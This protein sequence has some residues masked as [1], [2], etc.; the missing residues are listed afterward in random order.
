MYRFLAAASVAVSFGLA[1]TASLP[2]NA[3]GSHV[4][5]KI[6]PIAQLVI[7]N[8]GI[9]VLRRPHALQHAGRHFGHHRRVGLGSDF[10]PFWPNGTVEGGTVI[11]NISVGQGGGS[12]VQAVAGIREAPTA[13]PAIYVLDSEGRQRAERR[14]GARVLERGASG[15]AELDEGSAQSPYSPRIVSVPVR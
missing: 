3:G 13:R 6:R 8:P 14:S 1:T 9:G 4:A 2:A 5:P 10:F 7:G 15:W 12:G 11:N